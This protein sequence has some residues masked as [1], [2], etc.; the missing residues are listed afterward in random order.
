MKRI[1]SV[2]GAVVF[3]IVIGGAQACTESPTALGNDDDGR[4]CTWVKGILHCVEN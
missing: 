3:L 2:L 1:R 4:T